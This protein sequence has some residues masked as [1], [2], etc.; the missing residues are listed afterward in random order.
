MRAETSTCRGEP[1]TREHFSLSL[2][3]AMALHTGPFPPVSPGDWAC[4]V[5]ILVPRAP[6]SFPSMASC[7]LGRDPWGIPG[8]QCHRNSVPEFLKGVRSIPPYIH[9]LPTVHFYLPHTAWER[10]GYKIGFSG[11]TGEKDVALNPR[12]WALFGGGSGVGLLGVN[13][14]RWSALSKSFIWKENSAMP[15]TLGCGPCPSG[16]C[17]WRSADRVTPKF[18][19]RQWGPSFWEPVF[20]ARPTELPQQTPHAAQGDKTFPV[21]QGPTDGPALGPAHLHPRHSNGTAS[22][23]SPGFIRESEGPREHG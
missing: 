10:L 11:I 23:A 6:S 13:R 17:P 22:W 18:S 21:S 14:C 12:V 15:G 19:P 7:S 5:S 8:A 2:A 16:W 9:P 1:N 4:P 3:V 20:W